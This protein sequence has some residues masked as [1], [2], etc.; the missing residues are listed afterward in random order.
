LSLTQKSDKKCRFAKVSVKRL[1]GV[2]RL[3]NDKGLS[4]S[5]KNDFLNYIGGASGTLVYK[6]IVGLNYDIWLNSRL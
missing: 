2:S 1:A 4:K 6:L 5:S 3:W